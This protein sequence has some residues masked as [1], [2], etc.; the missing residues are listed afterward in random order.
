MKTADRISAQQPSAMPVSKYRPFVEVNPVDLPDRQWPTRRTT[1]APRWLSTDLRDGNQSLIEPM[2][3]ER[4]RRM[5]D[6][7]VT[8]GYKEIEIGFPAAS[9]T[10]RAKSS[11]VSTKISGEYW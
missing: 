8:M 2:N 7:L 9:Q 1:R 10:A 3:A 11:S 5:F 4:K 6:L